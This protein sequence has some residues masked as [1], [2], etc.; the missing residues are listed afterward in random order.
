ML[1]RGWTRVVA[2]DA[3]LILAALL[4]W[5]WPNALPVRNLDIISMV[6]AVVALALTILGFGVYSLNGVVDQNSG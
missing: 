1:S 5:T 6:I 3:L 4:F 2:V